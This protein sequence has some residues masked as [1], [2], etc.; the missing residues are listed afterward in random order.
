M[1]LNR[2]L[3]VTGVSSRRKGEEIIRAGR[4]TIN[5]DVVEDPAHNVDPD[6]DAVCVDGV[7]AVV[8]TEKR[9]FVM[10]KPTGVIVSRGDTH[11]RA[12][13]YDLLGPEARGVFSI[14]RLDVDTSGVLVFTDDGDAANRLMHPSFGVE[15]VYRAEVAG[16]VTSADARAI[17]RGIEL[18]DGMTAPAR[19]SILS[20]DER[21]SIV[22]LTIH[23]G[24]KRQVRRMFERLGHPVKTLDRLA[25]GGITVDS[26]G[27]GT[28]RPLYPGEIELLKEQVKNGE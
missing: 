12:T 21:D 26:L 11:G 20:S 25:F 18:D 24:R 6:R 13:V 1:R 23:E 7:S 3:S 22:E 19:L 4:V 28:Y 10:N 9:W 27:C 8:R 2:Y 15:K 17:A 16:A 5:G 14:G